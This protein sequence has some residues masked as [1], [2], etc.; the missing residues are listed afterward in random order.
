MERGSRS[1]R[2][3]VMLPIAKPFRSAKTIQIGIGM[4]L[5][6]ALCAPALWAI[7]EANGKRLCV[8]L[9]G[10]DAKIGRLL[11]RLDE[12]YRALNG[13]RY[14]RVIN[15]M[16]LTDEY[17]DTGWRGEMIRAWKQDGKYWTEVEWRPL[18]IRQCGNFANVTARVWY[19]DSPLV[20][21]NEPVG[22]LL[23]HRWWIWQGND[24][25]V[26]EQIDRRVEESGKKLH[27]HEGDYWN[28]LWIEEPVESL[29]SVWSSGESDSPE[30]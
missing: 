16:M 29:V 1:R 15:K 19:K 18:E 25:F 2:I 27:G 9:D 23:E 30:P 26:T 7:T 12:F 11:E 3:R 10:N 5:L 21:P 28:K 24:W 8:P 17:S 4:G 13:K 14:R 20:D 22:V 6:L